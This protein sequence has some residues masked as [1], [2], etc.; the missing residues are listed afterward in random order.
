MIAYITNFWQNQFFFYTGRRYPI[1]VAGF[2][3]VLVAVLLA[4][5]STRAEV[6]TAVR[7]STDIVRGDAPLVV[8]FDVLAQTVPSDAI[9]RVE[10][11]PG[12]GSNTILAHTGR[13][14]IRANPRFT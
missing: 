7:L 1:W 10:I 3:V 12:D 13:G 4:T 14:W 8:R 9:A 2:V 11:D 6:G 5:G